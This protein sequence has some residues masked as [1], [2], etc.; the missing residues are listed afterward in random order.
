MPA[1]SPS[2]Q[3]I[4]TENQQIKDVMSQAI[5]KLQERMQKSRERE[6]RYRKLAMVAIPQEEYN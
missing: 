3:K 5:V 4:L 2:K 1:A 6:L